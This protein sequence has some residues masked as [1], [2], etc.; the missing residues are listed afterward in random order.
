MKENTRMNE[1]QEIARMNTGSEKQTNN[2]KTERKKR[3]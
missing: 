2:R 1:E 3:K